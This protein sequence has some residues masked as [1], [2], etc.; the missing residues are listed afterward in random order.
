[1]RRHTVPKDWRQKV[2][3]ERNGLTLRI[4]SHSV[5]VVGYLETVMKAGSQPLTNT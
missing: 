3:V 1:M 4:F 2:L 5:C